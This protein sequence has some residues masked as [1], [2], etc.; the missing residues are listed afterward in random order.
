MIGW[1][2]REVVSERGWVEMGVMRVDYVL[3]YLDIVF[4]NFRRFIGCV[5]KKG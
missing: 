5:N 2:E 1:I 4:H 3:Q